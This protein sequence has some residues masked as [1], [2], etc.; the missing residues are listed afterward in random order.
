M[1]RKLTA[2]PV[3]QRLQDIESDCSDGDLCDSE[4]HLGYDE[5]PSAVESDEKTTVTDS[6][7]KD[8]DHV[9]VT[10]SN[11]NDDGVQHFIGKDGS[12]WRILSTFQ[13]QRGRLQQQ[14]VVNVRPAPTEFATNRV[15][16]GSPSSSFRIIFS[17][18][19]FRNIQK[20]VSEAQRVTRD[21]N[22]NVTLHELDKFICL[23]ITRG[24][25][26]QTGLPCSLWNTFWSAQC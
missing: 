6:S 22:W 3:L 19:M 10:D 5:P 15:I 17:K 16:E 7:D 4:D 11:G 20:C 25:L 1:V 13:V 8:T 14:N 26:G 24:V 23:I 21:I 2:H 12:S 9:A 18:A